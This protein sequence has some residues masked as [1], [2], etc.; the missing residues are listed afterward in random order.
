MSITELFTIVK[1]WKQPKAPLT[2]DWINKSGIQWNI[3]QP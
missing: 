3:T 2:D 1:I